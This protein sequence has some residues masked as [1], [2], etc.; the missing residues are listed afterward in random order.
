MKRSAIE[1]AVGLLARREHSVLEIRRKLEQ[2]KYAEE[3]VSRA[4]EQLQANNLLSEERFTESYINMR[5]HRG[6]GPLRIEQE[7]RERG[8]TQDVIDVF[9]EKNDEEWK[10]IMDQQYSKKY[11]NKPAEDYAEKAKRAQ[12]LQRRG[13]PLDWVFKL[14]PVDD[15]NQ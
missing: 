15:I 11:A 2:R 8:V 9:L 5:K 6:Y 3:D 14:S 4:I 1:A 12:Y 13:F 7:L 10:L